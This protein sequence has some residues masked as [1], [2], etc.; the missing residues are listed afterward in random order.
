LRTALLISICFL[1]SVAINSFAANYS[2]SDTVFS[3]LPI[4]EFENKDSVLVVAEYSDLFW[5]PLHSPVSIAPIENQGNRIENTLK[6]VPGL[7]VKNYGGR[8]GISTLSIRGASSSSTLVLLNGMRLSSPQTGMFDFSLI[9][10]NLF[11]QVDILKGGSGVLYGSNAMAGIVN[12][13]TTSG[14]SDFV[15]LGYGSF[16]D[17]NVDISKVLLDSSLSFA[18]SFES[19]SGRYPFEKFNRNF[20][21]QNASFDRFNLITDLNLGGEGQSRLVSWTHYNERGIPGPFIINNP[22]NTQTSSSILGQMFVYSETRQ[23]QLGSVNS[24]VSF[25]YQNFLVNQDVSI[26]TLSDIRYE[27]YELHLRST[28]KGDFLMGNYLLTV[29]GGASVLDGDNLD[30]NVGNKITREWAAMA[31]QNSYQLF[32]DDS[33]RQSIGLVYGGRCD[34]YSDTELLPSFYIGAIWETGTYFDL[35]IEA[36]YNGRVP[37]FNELY[38]LNYG[39]SDLIPEKNIS[40]PLSLKYRNEVIDGIN[41]LADITVFYNVF[42]DMILAIPKS[43]LVTTAQNI[44]S[45]NI[46]GYELSTSILEKDLMINAGYIRQYPLE[47]VRGNAMLIPNIPQETANIGISYQKGAIGA[48]STFN[49]VSFRYTTRGEDIWNILPSYSTLDANLSYEIQLDD[50]TLQN[51]IFVDNVFDTHYEIILN[52]PM[53]GRLIGIN[54]KVIF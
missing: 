10:S 15:S 43:P 5:S 39:N 38:Y 20:Q 11:S 47:Y 23:T 34:Y 42:H 21:R 53:P 30:P 29:E 37:S 16:D 18:A 50:L 51:T 22:E 49:Y 54:T 19:F 17:Y 3:I 6:T 7:F 14:R 52:Y 40:L 1:R 36:S 28:L 32:N 46:Y 12:L 13:N 41:L 8:S 31:F 26:N 33:T 4:T 9:S 24:G 35:T 25:R 44:G 2:E 27:N 45:S 48:S